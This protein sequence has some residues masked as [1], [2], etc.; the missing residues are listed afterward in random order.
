M[1]LVLDATMLPPLHL[2]THVSTGAFVLVRSHK[3]LRD[4]NGDLVGWR[5]NGVF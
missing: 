4:G 3:I 2:L 1:V 5:R